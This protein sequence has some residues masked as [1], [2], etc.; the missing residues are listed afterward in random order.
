MSTMARGTQ[1]AAH[2]L[3][4]INDPA[5][6]QAMPADPCNPG[7]LRTSIVRVAFWQS[8]ANRGRIR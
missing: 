1:P 2:D 4:S 5:G 8:Q 3:R 6:I 7:I